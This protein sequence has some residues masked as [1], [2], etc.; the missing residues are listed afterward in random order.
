MWKSAEALYRR[1]LEGCEKTLGL[2]HPD[3][4]TAAYG[5]AGTLNAT[6]RRPEAIALLR[7]FAVLSAESRD[8]VAYNLA[9]YECLEGNHEEAKNLLSEHL[10]LH[11]DLKAQ[12]LADEDFAAIRDWIE[13]L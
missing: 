11:P 5:L 9:C 13:D 8:A 6:D 10:A 1:A 12:A 3:T 4:D 7:R 2:K